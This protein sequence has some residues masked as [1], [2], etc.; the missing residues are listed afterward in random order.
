MGMPIW[1]ENVR[2]SAVSGISATSLFA[3]TL[4]IFNEFALYKYLSCNGSIIFISVQIYCADW[5]TRPTSEI[6]KISVI[7]IG[8]DWKKSK[9]SCILY[10]YVYIATTHILN[11][12]NWGQFASSRTKRKKYAPNL[13]MSLL[14]AFIVFEQMWMCRYLICKLY[15]NCIFMNIIRYIHYMIIFPFIKDVTSWKNVAVRALENRGG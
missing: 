3:S 6:R 12:Q 7:R 4:D 13:L 8:A 1:R 5:V 2:Q 15:R 11:F 14:F 10:L 9:V